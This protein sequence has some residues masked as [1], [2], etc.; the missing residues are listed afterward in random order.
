MDDSRS[1]AMIMEIPKTRTSLCPLVK[2]ESTTIPKIVSEKLK[3]TE[4]VSSHSFGSK[5]LLEPSM[6][7]E[8]AKEAS[9]CTHEALISHLEGSDAVLVSGSDCLV[10]MGHLKYCSALTCAPKWQEEWAQR[11]GSA[12]SDKGHALCCATDMWLE[13]H[14]TEPLSQVAD[15]HESDMPHVD[16]DSFADWCFIFFFFCIIT[17][18]LT[19]G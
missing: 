17:N 15:S 8:S 2:R 14:S 5:A 10:L 9:A 1:K 16:F 6:W 11:E 19:V 7:T 3:V 12:F 13:K 4:W 18:L